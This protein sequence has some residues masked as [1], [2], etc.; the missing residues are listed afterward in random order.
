MI[1]SHCQDSESRNKADCLLS[2]D[3]ETYSQLLRFKS[4]EV[5]R[6]LTNNVKRWKNQMSSG[7]SKQTIQDLI[8]SQSA[9]LQLK[10]E[11]MRRTEAEAL[12]GMKMKNLSP[13]NVRRLPLIGTVQDLTAD[14]LFCPKDWQDSLD[15]LDK[16]RLLSKVSF[17][18]NE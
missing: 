13:R 18:V 17:L 1:S 15:L 5:N 12:S 3:E 4:Y 11:E 8:D 14:I 10:L 2:E 9:S 16:T 6:L 7:G